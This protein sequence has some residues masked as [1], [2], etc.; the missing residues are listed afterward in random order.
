ML[1]KTLIFVVFIVFLL[2]CSKKYSTDFSAVESELFLYNKA[3]KYLKKNDLDK[4]LGLY[5]STQFYNKNSVLRKK[6]IKKIDSLMP[7]FQNSNYKQIKGLWKLKELHFNPEPGLFTEYIEF[8]DTEINFYTIDSLG[9]ITLS[10]KENIE[11]PKY[12]SISLFLYSN[13]FVFKNSEQWH[14][15]VKKENGK[16]KLYPTIQKNSKGGGGTMMLDER[17][18]IR[19]KRERRKALKKELYT[20]YVLAK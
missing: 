13:H 18:I 5:H 14:F 15:D 17:G 2:S 12:D 16:L 10:R 19:N 9:L 6:A 8:N 7:I 11:H 4:A 3:E 1:K 20:Y